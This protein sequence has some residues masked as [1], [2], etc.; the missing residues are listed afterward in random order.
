[1]TESK[2]YYKASLGL[3]NEIV[4]LVQEDYSSDF[5][6]HLKNQAD[7]MA[8]PSA[9]CI[10]FLA[11][12]FGFC[13][14][15]DK[16]IDLAYEARRK[17][18]DKRIFLLTE[19]IHNPRVNQ[20]LVDMGFVFLSG[21]YQHPTLTKSDITADDVVLIPAFGTA[22]SDFDFLRSKGCIIVDTTCG[23]VVHVWKR[24]EKYA[25]EGY[26]SLVH[27]KFYHEETI[28]TVSM[29]AKE[30][31]HYLVVRNHSQTDLVIQYLLGQLTATEL[32]A[33]FDPQAYSPGFNPDYHLQ[34]MGVANQTTML[35]SESL[36]IAARIGDAIAQR[37]AAPSRNEATNFRSFDTICSAT[38]DRQDA[39]KHLLSTASLDLM[40]IIGGYNSSNTTHLLSVSQEFST[41]FHIDDAS[42]LLSSAEILHLPY[43]AAEPMVST[44]WIPQ[45]GERPLRVGFTAGA[46]TPNKVIHDVVKRFVEIRGG[47]LS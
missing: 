16:A 28:A 1:M 22:T 42:E 25:R 32:L 45:V 35:A 20:R 6:L 29:A 24:V 47:T 38:Q 43:G 9:N 18:P 3:K 15:V 8:F 17:F 33:K 36:E 19:I 2:T 13:Y 12:E 39:V 37:D 11:K 41:A 5:V 30:G 44:P 14:G 26:T 4:G 21:Q 10:A 46:S 34:K 31:G 40:I 27:G 23:S 7:G